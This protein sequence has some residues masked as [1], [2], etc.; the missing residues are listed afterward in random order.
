M[1]RFANRS[2]PIGIA[3]LLLIGILTLLA[4]P[5]AGEVVHEGYFQDQD[6]TWF[7]DSEGNFQP[8]LPGATL[9][10]QPGL[11]QLLGQDLLLLVPADLK[12]AEA[13][14]EPIVTHKLDQPGPIKLGV[15]L[16]T[17][18]GELISTARMAPAEGFF[19]ATWGEFKG[20]HTWRGYR[21]LAVSV[22]PLREGPGYLE[23]LDSYAVH[24]RYEGTVDPR[25]LATRERA[26]AGE[27]Q[28]NTSV[29]ASL[30]ANPEMISG[31]G[32][33]SGVIVEKA[34]AGFVPEKS[35]SL[36]GSAVQ[37]LI[38][39]NEAMAEEFQRLADHKTA[40][41]INT[42]V[43]TR[44][45][46]TANFRNG[47]DIQE[48]VRMFIRDAYQKWGTDYVLLG[49]DTDVLPARYVTNSFYPATGSTDIPVDLYFACLDGNWN[50][51]ANAFYGEPPNGFDSG[52]DV[53][54]AEEVY[55]GRATVSSADA[56]AVFVDKVISYESTPAGASWPERVI[57][58]AEV[59]FPSEYEDGL[60]II[61]DGAQFSHQMVND[62]VE[63][64][65]DMSTTRM[66][67]TDV[68]YPRD[69]PLNRSAL[70][71]TLNTGH[72]GIF[73]QIGHGYFF[74]MSV[75]D[76]NFMTMDAD[77][78]VNGD[79]Y[80]MLFSLNCASC[81]FDYSCL[82]ER[83]LQN[84]NG[85][86]VVSIG[87]A[88]AAFPNTCNNYQQEFFSQLY[89]QNETRVGRLVALSRL[90]FL[91]NTVFNYVDRW[92]FE[93][94]TLLGDPSLP[95]WTGSPQPLA[96]DVSPVGLGPNTV[97]VNVTSYSSAIEGAQV[98]LA[99][100]GE[101]HAFGT[102]DQ[103]GSVQFDYL[104]TDEGT[105]Q[106]TVSGKN[107]ALSS[108]EVSVVDG[109]SY[110]TISTMALLD[111]GAF[112][113]V[114]NGN[115]VVESGET[116]AL[117]PSI[118]ET[119]GQG[120]TG[121][122][123]TIFCPDPRVTILSNQFS[124]PDIGG[125]GSAPSTAPAL[126]SFPPS[127][128]DGTP[129]EFG[130]EVTD[131]SGGSYLSSWQVL[132]KA[133]E[134][135]IVSLDWEDSTYGN[136]DGWLDNGERV[137]LTVRAKNFGAG[138]AD[139]VDAVLRT[140]VPNV[141]L[142]DSLATFSG[143]ES[144]DESAASNTFSL[145]LTDATR[146]SVSR[147]LLTDSYGRTFTHEF[148]L[149]RPEPPMVIETDPSLG[150]D[151]IAV[152]WAPSALTG[153]KGYDLYRS[154]NEAGP[155]VKVNTDLIAGVSYFRDE[156]LELLTRY[157]YRIA[158]VGESL[159]ASPR[160][161]VVGQATAPAELS[162]FPVEFVDETS[163]HLAVGD[164]DGDGTLEIVMASD[165]V[166]VWHH[167]GTELL[168]GDSNSQTLGPFTNLNTILQP[169]GIVLAQL[170][171]Q[172]GLEM[173]VSDRG[174]AI[175]I[176][177]FRKDG[178]VLPG[179]PQSLAGLP[180]TDWNW[181]TPAVGDLDGDGDPEIVVNTVNGVT[182]AWHQDGSEVLDGDANPATHGVFFTREGATFEWSHSSPALYDL[183][184]D[185][186]KDIIFGCKTDN[187]GVKRL[188]ALKSDGTNV[189]G[190]PYIAIGAIDNSPAVGDLNNDGVMEI[191]FYDWAQNLY[192]VQEDGT[193]YPG[194]P[195]NY[196]V[197]SSLQPAPSVALGD[198]DI[199]GQL[200]I[201]FAVNVAGDLS[202]MM[203]FDTDVAGGTSG[204]LLSGWPKDLPGSS[205]SSPVLGD[206]D[207]DEIPDIIFGIGG[208]NEDSPNNMYAFHADGQAIDGFPITLTGP[209][210]PSPVITDLDHDFDV[211]IVYGG[212][213]R[214][215][216]VWDMPFAYDRRNVPWPTFHGN[217]QRDGVLFPIAMV[218]VDDPE[219]QLPT[220]LKVGTP[221]PNPFNPSTSV[222]LY[223]PGETGSAELELSVYDVLGR[224]VRVLHQGAISPGWHTLVWDGRD[225]KGQGQ[226]SGMYFMR[227]RS[228]GLD[229]IRKMTLLK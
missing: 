56:A 199:D 2:F 163:S 44:E 65:T 1:N 75:G 47:A 73:N 63:P 178:S 188:M 155:F 17:S 151:V 108:Q 99:R 221:Y 214:I 33:E 36:S 28:A 215:V 162:G 175:Q 89:C 109:D 43:A 193:D 18:T 224:R 194:F 121:I 207:G 79:H 173:I 50:A 88:R 24:V 37:Y 49:G 190:F 6:L 60:N 114:G 126:V 83:F 92:T 64:C 186:G 180:G 62:L 210:W 77:N 67:E 170:D 203:V 107:L 223:V 52:D 4:G 115:L 103:N 225:D 69:A 183:D 10:G 105:I 184:H 94:Y 134:I 19:P 23:F 12:V 14:I 70:S 86:S 118:V 129:I 147:I 133:P 53:D 58:A 222:R 182:W 226:A 71:D 195:V 167:D 5:S 192:V 227:A 8:G 120:A 205:E 100:P 7:A 41:G 95:I 31:Y 15:P 11:P 206:I 156:G 32:R 72:Y 45:Y 125:G 212:W 42:V 127:L 128:P 172:P 26:V 229:A 191:V 110:F 111:N 46:I 106:L 137:N 57:Y 76:G 204:D 158:A 112:D 198:M 34:S 140:D 228:S 217:M 216:H 131:S 218:G 152:R 149:Q 132:M 171:D 96:L 166:Y 164:I 85:G 21:L 154:M 9:L 113:S 66:Y 145:A 161:M 174:T 208:F 144:M 177:I 51:N 196:G 3:T 90:P 181:A 165:E 25:E 123:G 119:A 179:W 124:F 211:D 35:P 153:V 197:G 189:P 168:D 136:G 187:S 141:T 87:S 142:H 117:W 48:T 39:T 201:V 159:I 185:G 202:T 81:A 209:I 30:V 74:N 59:L 219:V 29:L 27:F 104:A 22:H 82:M 122:A 146:E 102:T 97:T 148:F 157:Y 93:N 143:L 55:I 40:Q 80:F 176:Y 54:F 84:P 98:C 220:A 213:D 78:L 169:S 16:A 160:S 150:A 116:V 135:E 130:L 138:R 101:D 20:T 91:A 38:I 200:E 139:L 61:L 68:L 13:W